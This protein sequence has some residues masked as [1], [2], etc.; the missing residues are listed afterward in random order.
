M[1]ILYFT[2]LHGDQSKYNMIRSL[3]EKQDVQIIINGGDMLPKHN[4]L[5]LDQRKFIEGFLDKHFDSFNGKGIYYLNCLGND[6]LRVHDE[7]FEEVC[8]K[9]PFV[10]NLAQKRIEISGFEFIGMNWVCDYPFRLKDRCRIDGMNFVFPHQFGKGLLSTNNGYEEIENWTTFALTLPSI[11]EELNRLQSCDNPRKTIYVMHMPPRNQGLDTCYSGEEVG[12][13][14][15]LEFI[16]KVQ[17]LYTLHGHIHE[18]PE[19]AGRWFNQI[20]D[21]VCIQPGQT[22]FFPHVVIDLEKHSFELFEL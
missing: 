6:D 22:R 5:F 11:E 20:R 9:Y 16:E 13:K 15:V 2:D 4:N 21:T 12:S 8:T 10:T 14:S 18:S 1:R 19:V 7:L 3:V 17:P